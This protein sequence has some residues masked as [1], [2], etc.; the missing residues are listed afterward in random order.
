MPTPAASPI[1]IS[2]ISLRYEDMSLTGKLLA[3]LARDQ[4]VATDR[5]IEEAAT[6]VATGVGQDSEDELFSQITSAVRSYLSAPKSFTVA[7]DLPQPVP[8]Q[9]FM[10][11]VAQG[12]AE[13]FARYPASVSVND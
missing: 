12:P 8:V 5:L 9:A 2:G 4:G 11:S 3:L 13:F 6:A 10:E 1:M 7:S